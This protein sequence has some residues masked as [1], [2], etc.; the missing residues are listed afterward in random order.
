MYLLEL[1]AQGVK[2]C[3]PSARAALSPGYVVL[4]PPSAEPF[5]LGGLSLALLYADGRGG[6]AV[7]AAQGKAKVA[8]TLQGNDLT[9]YR[10]VRELGG[11]GVLQRLNRQ[12]Q[13]FEVV[14][15]DAQEMGQFLRAQVGLPQRTQF[16]V[17]YTL[18]SAQLPS[19]RPKTVAAASPSGKKPALAQ[20]APVRPAEDL[21]QA[22]ARLGELERELEL[23]QSVDQL[24]FRLDGIAS[25]MFELETKLKSTQTLQEQ[26]GEAQAAWEAA[27]TP[28]SV[29]VPA[30]ILEHI[31]RYPA[32]V[33]KRD[34]A[35]AR[36]E[37]E[38]QSAAAEQAQVV[39]I[40]PLYRDSR[41]L[42]GVGL[43]LLCLAA[44]AALDGM[45]R[46][47][48]LLDIPFFGFAA[49]VALRWIDDLQGTQRTNRKGDFLAAREK[50]IVEDFE[51]GAQPVKRALAALRL[52]TPQEVAELLSRKAG[53]GQKVSELQQ[54]LAQAEAD[55]EFARAREQYEDFRRESEAINADLQQRSGGFIRDPREVE[56]E[57]ARVRESI[58]LA[59]SPAGSPSVAVEEGPGVETGGGVQFE[60]P[61][62]V[63]FTQAADLLQ[64]DVG[65]LA[66][67]VRDRCGQ[68]VA[69]LCERRYV[70]IEFDPHGRAS[71]LNAQGKVPASALPAKD[72]DLYFLALRMTLVERL[73]AKG[74]IPLLIED[75]SGLVDEPR[76]PLFGR[77][78]K[79]LG[80]LTQ[81]IHVTASP[82]L[83]G[84]ADST[85]ML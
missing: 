50:K 77:M 11:M 40:E 2:G 69:A 29:G 59:R 66:A 78:L 68:Y 57:I 81:V 30:D 23:S 82:A 64:T 39:T 71:L 27:P 18:A 28:E 13:R 85:A 8:I 43:G 10:L 80:T 44:G 3:S 32:L 9:T 7:F 54:W 17:L 51:A 67:A 60:D 46:Y 22:E 76:V 37:Q 45:L 6:D 41:F 34:E 49:V 15:Q 38:R 20:A 63:L 72:V 70:G 83:G 19:K 42:I 58:A 73:S 52:E 48:A 16:E 21:G 65:S 55:P 79:H 75:L 1:A 53:L 74:K 33:Q 84:V 62:P 26:L 25:Q 56:R 36:L 31:E 12:A 61:G 4:R 14:T 5:A 47:L 35:L 24:Q